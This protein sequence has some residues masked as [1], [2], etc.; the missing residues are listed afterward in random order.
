MGPCPGQTGK[1]HQQMTSKLLVHLSD[2]DKWPIALALIRSLLDQS[3]SEI[4]IIVDIFAVGICVACN[5]IIA[6][7]MQALVDAGHEILLCRDSLQALNI[8][9]RNLPEF[10]SVI[11]N[12]LT[13]ILKRRAEGWQ[14][15]KF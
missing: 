12:S 4:V 9:A 8:P 14:Y 6:E 13:E 2:R 11:P 5:K 3:H 15:I 1:P 7:Q 10:M